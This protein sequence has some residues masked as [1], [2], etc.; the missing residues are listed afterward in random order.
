[1][2]DLRYVVEEWTLDESRPLEVIARVGDLPVAT[3]P[4]WS[5]AAARPKARIVLRHK[6]RELARRAPTKWT[7]AR[8]LRKSTLFDVQ[9]G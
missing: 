5:V 1:M 7:A 6:G 8:L 2:E 4:F 3:S 9:D